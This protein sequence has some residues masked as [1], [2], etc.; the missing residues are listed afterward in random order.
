MLPG[1]CRGGIEGYGSDRGTTRAGP[2]YRP[3]VTTVDTRWMIMS[4]IVPPPTA[5]IE[6]RMAAGNIRVMTNATAVPVTQ[7]RLESG[8][9]ERCHCRIAPRPAPVPRRRSHPHAAQGDRRM[10]QVAERGQRIGSD[11]YVPDDPS[12]RAP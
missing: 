5:V 3:L 6:P 8:G 4:R 9:V 11:P 1:C 12:A 10:S 2:A 7:K